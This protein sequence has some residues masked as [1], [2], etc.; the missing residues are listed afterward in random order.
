MSESIEFSE[1]FKLL[2]TIKKGE[3]ERTK[4]LEEKIQEYK[5]G[6]NSKSFLEEL[7]QKFLYVG[8][9]ELYKYSNN[10]NLQSISE[11]EKESWE[12]LAEKNEFQLPQ[13]LANAMM[14]YAK[15][16]KLSKQISK[17]WQVRERELNKHIRP[18][19]QYITEGI[20]DFLE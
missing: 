10:K 3:L 7:G 4:V 20:I 8:I 11:M 16:N 9:S 5:E 13:Y 19:A 1:F 12:E 6:K 17:K 18:M 15:E 2:D 14:N